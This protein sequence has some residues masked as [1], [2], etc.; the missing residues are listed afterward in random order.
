[1]D[2]HPTA[3]DLRAKV[4]EDRKMP[5]NWRVEKFRRLGRYV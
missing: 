1:M 4:F 3:H 5:G 2:N